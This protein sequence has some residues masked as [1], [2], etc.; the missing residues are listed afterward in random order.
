[1][2]KQIVWITLIVLMGYSNSL[3]WQ[4]PMK[5]ELKH[6]AMSEQHPNLQHDVVTA[7]L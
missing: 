6:D 5:Y 4:L 1:M 7:Q 2:K 3:D